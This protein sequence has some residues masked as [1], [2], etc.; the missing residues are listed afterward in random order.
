MWNYFFEMFQLDWWV[1]FGFAGQ[2]IFFA[3]FVVQWLYSEKHHQSLIPVQFWYLSIIGA[4]IV[5]V[6]AV[7]RRDPVFFLGQLFAIVIYA[8][9]LW[10]IKKAKQHAPHSN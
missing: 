7:K 10:L 5:F 9:N 8:R 1:V 2:M 3:R 4:V 6:Y